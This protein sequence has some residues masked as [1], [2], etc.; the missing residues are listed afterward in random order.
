MS[1]ASV[2]SAKQPNSRSAELRERFTGEDVGGV[3]GVE[4]DSAEA[5]EHGEEERRR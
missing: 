2:Q 4:V 1:Y 5:G 3:V